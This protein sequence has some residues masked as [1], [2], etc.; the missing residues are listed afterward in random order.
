[1]VISPPIIESSFSHKAADIT[2]PH[3]GQDGEKDPDKE[4]KGVGQ[5]NKGKEKKGKYHQNIMVTQILIHIFL[6]NQRGGKV[7]KQNSDNNN[8]H[9]FQSME[10]Q[11]NSYLR[12]NIYMQSNSMANQLY[13]QAIDRQSQLKNTMNEKIGNFQKNNSE[14]IYEA[15][16]KLSQGSEYFKQLNKDKGEKLKKNIEEKINE[17]TQYAR[18]Y[19][20][21]TGDKLK[22]GGR[23][24]A[25]SIPNPVQNLNDSY[26]GGKKKLKNT[27]YV[28]Y[29]MALGAIGVYGFAN[30]FGRG[31]ASSGSQG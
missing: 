4:M 8:R 19:A 16:Q 22:E 25:D 14:S 17:S 13:N 20:Q 3:T 27:I 6:E 11:V 24:V 5:S 1:M 29:A 10:Q 31:L 23:K 9:N 15:S 2:E 21:E 30:G 7:Y 12:T 18:T 28:A 26:Q